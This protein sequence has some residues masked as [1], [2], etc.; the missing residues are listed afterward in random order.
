VVGLMLVLLGAAVFGP[1]IVHGGFYYDD[2]AN[3]AQTKYGPQA[4]FFAAIRSWFDTAGARPGTALYMPLTHELLGF[5]IGAHLALAAVWAIAMSLAF[6]LLL[7]C[8]G[9]ERLSALLIAAL[10]LVFPFSDSTRLNAVS[11]LSS[12]AITLYLVG[13]IIAVIAFRYARTPLRWH[14]VSIA[15]YLVSVLTYEITAGPVVV[16]GLGLYLLCAPSRQALVRWVVDVAVVA[17]ALLAFNSRSADKTVHSLGYMFDHARVILD[18]GVGILA[19]ALSPFGAPNQWGALALIVLVLAVGIAAFRL[20]GPGADRRELRRWLL[21]CGGGLLAIVAGYLMF[22]PADVYYSPAT[23]GVGNRVNAFAA[24]G[25][26]TVA[27]A[28]AMLFGTL[29]FR[30]LKGARAAAVTTAALV[31]VAIGAGYIDLV[32]ADAGFWDRAYQQEQ[33]V[34]GTINRL[35]PNPR[36]GSTILAVGQPLFYAPGIPVF[37][38]SWD[39]D[40]AVKI[41]YRDHSVRAQPVAPGETVACRPDGVALLPGGSP[42]GRPIVSSPYGRTYIVHVP[43]AEPALVRSLRACVA[44]APHLKPGPAQLTPGS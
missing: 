9:I 29:A 11:G 21:V 22:I 14:A 7:R 12:F 40:G 1:H 24:L 44:L 43:Q 15:F 32:R 30:G 35:V 41:Q 18:Q 25:C 36:H 3:Y 28:L 23:L 4:G 38:A 2:W 39:L 5:H 33:Y 8:L 31:A 37:A 17:L 19:S 27:Y 20:L 10:A 42:P 26:V 13:A 16:L 34:L 6:Y